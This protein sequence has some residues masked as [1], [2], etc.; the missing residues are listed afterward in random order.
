M[1]L[2]LNNMNLPL[3]MDVLALSASIV[4]ILVLIVNRRRYGRMIASPADKSNFTST[5]A[6]QMVTAQSRR[7]YSRIQRT[8]NQE[9]ARL[10]RMTGSEPP[11]RATDPVTTGAATAVVSRKRAGLY[12]E[13]T[14]MM[15]NGADR[16]TVAAR[17]DLTR[18][19]IELMAYMQHKR[20]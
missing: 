11:C 1:S 5:L 12:D 16:Q 17:C 19:E 4:L 9:F 8:L 7:S 15:R 14:R 20:S 13:A 6:L 3:L 2:T 18:G 10:Q